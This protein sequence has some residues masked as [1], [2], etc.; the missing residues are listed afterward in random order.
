MLLPPDVCE[1]AVLVLDYFLVEMNRLVKGII[2]L[3]RVDPQLVSDLAR[4]NDWLC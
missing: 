4:R 2:G 3:A 1:I